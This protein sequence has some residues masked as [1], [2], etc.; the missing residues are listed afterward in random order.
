MI[1]FVVLILRKSLTAKNAK[2]ERK[3]KQQSKA[4]H[5][6]T[7]NKLEQEHFSCRLV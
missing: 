3:E 4:I 1:Y 7:R 5:E 2:Y 6:K